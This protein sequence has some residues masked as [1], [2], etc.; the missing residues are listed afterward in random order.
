MQE[1]KNNQHDLINYLKNILLNII[2]ESEIDNYFTEESIKIWNRAFIHESIN[3]SNNNEELEYLGDAILKA[4]FPYYLLKKLP[5]LDKSIYTE[6]NSFYMSKEEQLKLADYLKLEDYVLAIELK[7]S[8]NNVIGDMFEAFFGAL[9]EVSDLYFKGLGFYNCFNMIVYLYKNKEI[10]ESKGLGSG[11]TQVKQI[12]SRFAIHEPNEK[13]ISKDGK[14][15]CQIILGPEQLDFLKNHK[16]NIKNK[17]ELTIGKNIANTKKEAI[18]I[19]YDNA[20]EALRK[21]GVTTS[22]AENIKREDDRKIIEKYYNDLMKKLKKDGYI[23][24]YF[25]IPRKTVNKNGSTV[26]LV[27]VTK[28]K[29]S[30]SLEYVITNNKSNA[31]EEAKINVVKK[32]LNIE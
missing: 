23:D 21:L 29:I 30:K 31:Y 17:K 14:E 28:D 5:G 25:F 6:L 22:W 19:A 26:I 27:G 12:F 1:P 24:Y 4:V 15:E 20:L 2:D 7:N 13:I 11:K 8:R 10:D 3:P 16:I 32:Y 18:K 9:T